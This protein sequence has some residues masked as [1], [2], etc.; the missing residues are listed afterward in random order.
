VEVPTD[1]STESDVITMTIE[2]ERNGERL[3][4]LDSDSTMEERFRK[5]GQAC[6]KEDTAKAKQSSADCSTVVAGADHRTMSESN[7]QRNC[8]HPEAK[9]ARALFCRYPPRFYG[10]QGICRQ[11]AQFCPFQ[12]LQL[13]ADATRIDSAVVNVDAELFRSLE[14]CGSLREELWIFKV[15]VHWCPHCQQLMPKFYRLA[16]VLLQKGVRKIRFGAINCAVEHELCSI[17]KWP[18]HPLFVAK[19]LGPDRAIHDAIEYWVDLVKDAQLRAMLPRY[20]L[21]GEYP[22][23]KVLMEQLPDTVAPT[24]SWENLFDADSIAETGA[25]PN[26]SALHA[27][28]PANAQDVVGN[29]WADYEGE[30]TPRRR[31][32]DALLMIR[33]TLQEWIV[34]LGDDGNVEAFSYLQMQ[35]VVAW[36]SLLERGLPTSFG[37]SASLA[38]L[39]RALRRRLRETQSSQGGGL[40]AKEW[41]SWVAPILQAIAEIGQ[42]EFG[43][44][45]ACASDTCRFWSLL[46]NLAG[47]AHTRANESQEGVEDKV[48]P[49]EILST[50][51]T[52]MEH[53]FKCLNC[54]Q[55][56]LE[57]FDKGSYGLASATEDTAGL[58]L[59]LWRFHNAV[60]VRV[61]AEHSC[62]TVDRRWP[63]FSLCPKCWDVG[64]SSEWEILQELKELKGSSSSSSLILPHRP[65]RLGALPNE[66]EVFHFLMSSFTRST[67]DMDKAVMSA[68]TPDLSLPMPP[69]PPPLET[70]AAL[71][72]PP[73]PL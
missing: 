48:S 73:P 45:S 31:W 7:G 52:F 70:S 43:V 19:Y 32:T 30:L 55:H 10:H 42:R 14:D 57:Q 50:I 15:Y 65:Q 61:A 71:P 27:K 9:E 8:N 12:E 56:F 62:Y 11:Y 34:P 17:Q 41:Q 37:L 28:T 35:A 1:A 66:S 6:L 47:E 36:V 59:Y 49:R 18:G 21:P 60:S 44:A 5:A 53:F 64:A 69:S 25:C 67:E 16:L 26:I 24:S 51:R 39:R 46:H 68:D 22:L 54:R 38:T 40:C 20:A 13:E 29:G 2:L 33:H 23:L 3:F 58:V 72:S 63:P 4:E